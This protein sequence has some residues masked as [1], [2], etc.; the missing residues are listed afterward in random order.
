MTKLNLQKKLAAA[1]MKV[2]QSRVWINPDKEKQK[3]LQSAITRADVKKFISK[4]DVKVKPEKV[5]KPKTAKEKKRRR[6]GPGSR[7][8]SKYARLP[9]KR[10]WM[11]TVRPL[12]RMLKDL[13][14]EGKLENVTYRKLYMLVKGGQ[15]RSRSHMRIYMEQHNMLKKEE[16]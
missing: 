4:G 14:D 15:F 6:K 1:I 9:S 16:K 11:N 5:K 8:G 7:K 13:K 3:E 2:G 12:R 10:R